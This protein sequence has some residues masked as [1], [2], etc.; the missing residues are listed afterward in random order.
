MLIL[1]LK[2]LVG[3]V[4]LDFEDDRE[5]V[6]EE[7]PFISWVSAWYALQLMSNLEVRFMYEPRSPSWYF[8][9]KNRH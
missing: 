8:E 3:S 6:P 9:E 4:E 2:E 5:E 7:P 1:D